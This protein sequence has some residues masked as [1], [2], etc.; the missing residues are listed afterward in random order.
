MFPKQTFKWRKQELGWMNS[1]YKK[2]ESLEKNLERGNMTLKTW[3]AYEELVEMKMYGIV[4]IWNLIFIPCHSNNISWQ[5]PREVRCIELK[6][7]NDGHTTYCPW[8]TRHRWYLFYIQFDDAFISSYSWFWKL[9][10]TLWLF[11][12]Y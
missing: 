11:P 7:G 5:C 2:H 12:R 6:E 8:S 3:H 9:F 10:S 4:F 1:I